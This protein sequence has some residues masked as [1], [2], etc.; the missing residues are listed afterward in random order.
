MFL[1]S[2]SWSWSRGKAFQSFT[3]KH[4]VSCQFF[5]LPFS[6]L[7]NFLSIPSLLSVFI[8]KWFWILSNSFSAFFLHLLRCSCAFSPH[9]SMNMV[10]YIDYFNILNQPCIPGI[11]STWLWYIV[12]FTCCWNLFTSNLL[13][14]SLSLFLKMYIQALYSIIQKTQDQGFGSCPDPVTEIP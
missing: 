1:I 14:I 12:L 5:W 7:C 8:M 6:W 4:D 9:Y 3:T 13:K 10:Y 11:N 2:L